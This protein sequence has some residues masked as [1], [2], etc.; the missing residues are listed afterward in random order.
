MGHIERVTESREWYARELAKAGADYE[1]ALRKIDWLESSNRVLHDLVAEYRKTKDPSGLRKMIVTV[2][3]VGTALVGGLV[4][5]VVEHGI[6]HVRGIPATADAAEAACKPGPTQTVGPESIPSGEQFETPT[7]RQTPTAGM[8]AQIP[9]DRTGVIPGR[10]NGAT[11]PSPARTVPETMAAPGGGA[12]PRDLTAAEV[13]RRADD[14]WEDPRPLDQDAFARSNRVDEDV[15]GFY[16]S[17]PVEDAAMRASAR[18]AKTLGQT[19]EEVLDTANTPGDAA[20][21]SFFPMPN[22]DTGSMITLAPDKAPDDTEGST[23]PGHS[24][25]EIRAA[26]KVMAESPVRP[27]VSEE[28]AAAYDRWSKSE[29]F[30]DND[31]ADFGVS[32][33]NIY[34]SEDGSS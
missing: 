24:L 28:Q 21:Q 18:S 19:I 32:D 10:G 29:G 20:Q 12:L 23:P 33:D 7:V 1:E 17:D 31:P 22:R 9:D 14:P 30:P 25:D 3:F 6:D 5:Y 2:S 4:S 27:L 8:G 11:I 34:L 16:S 26:V 13:Q 15:E